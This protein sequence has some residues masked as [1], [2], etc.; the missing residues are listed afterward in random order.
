MCCSI[1]H[2]LPSQINNRQD[3]VYYSPADNLT[4]SKLK[5]S[6]RLVL[7]MYCHYI[8]IGKICK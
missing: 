4:Y 1:L 6:D 8:H 7:S 5:V 2:R 3:Y